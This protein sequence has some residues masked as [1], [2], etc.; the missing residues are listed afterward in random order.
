MADNENIKSHAG[1]FITINGQKL[2]GGEPFESLEIKR[3]TSADC[4][5]LEIRKTIAR[6]ASKKILQFNG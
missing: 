4:V 2:V 1:I 6:F 5:L 3:G